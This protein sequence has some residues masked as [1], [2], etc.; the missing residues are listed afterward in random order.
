MKLCIA[1][2]KLFAVAT[3]LVSVALSRA[4]DIGFGVDPLFVGITTPRV[5]APYVLIAE[6]IGPDARGVFLVE[7]QGV[8]MRIP[9]DLPRGS[10][11]RV[12]VNL[13][14]GYPPP[15]AKLVTNR[16]TFEARIPENVG[17]EPGV[18]LVS[19]N[20]TGLGLRNPPDKRNA[21]QAA[22]LQ[23]LFVKPQDMPDRTASYY[24]V[25]GVILGDGAERMKDD[26]F[27]ALMN[28]MLLGGTVIIPG[29]ASAPILTDPK[30]QPF[31]P[32]SGASPTTLSPNAGESILGLSLSGS[33]TMRRGLVHPAARVLTEYRGI[34]AVVTRGFG[35]GRLLF[36]AFNPFER[37]IDS[38]T[39][40]GK[41]LRSLNLVSGYASMS[42][43]L[44]SGGF[45]ED[46][47]S[48][49]TGYGGGPTPSPMSTAAMDPQ[50]ND[51]FEAK[52]PD[53]FSVVGI[54]LIYVILVVPVNLLILRK[55]GKGEWAW[56]T[57]P[58]V[59]LGFAAVFFRFA[60]G[61]Y[62]ANMSLMIVGTLV[63]D[64]QSKST[65]FLGNTQMF[66]P[67]G[68]NYDL[69]LDGVE[70]AQNG[71]P[72]YYRPQ[73]NQTL[74]LVDTGEVRMPDLQV[75]NLAFREF[76]FSQK[77]DSGK[78]LR[79]SK[80]GDR[81]RLVNLSPYDLV[82]V[83]LR[84]KRALGM[85]GTLKAGASWEGVPVA[86][87]PGGESVSLDSGRNRV[88]VSGYVLGLRPGPKIGELAGN[89]SSVRLVYFLDGGNL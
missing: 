53:T 17:I 73:G 10:K 21:G 28:F 43:F 27:E 87:K 82:G 60:A 67:R 52:P 49:G 74:D 65:Y 34:P 48:Y 79:L 33:F 31:L 72:N 70:I 83:E 4:A 41:L 15:T 57:T 64:E 2:S 78:W 62:S 51:P 38:W 59:S 77:L 46:Y 76:S 20:A 35:A 40:K 30:W 26:A 23:E 9:V 58:L 89:R 75:P 12:S 16:G 50:V 24:G 84:S 69:K 44:Q 5:V 18:V 63:G 88:K 85:V 47:N 55:M 13:R 80:T 6:N 7:S 45:M 1:P 37:P 54:L 42:S 22:T 32:V 81:V 14:M 29:G 68:G 86:L 19:D 25:T 39:G 3:C 71:M 56:I 36:L 61:L 66:F 11:K 8:T